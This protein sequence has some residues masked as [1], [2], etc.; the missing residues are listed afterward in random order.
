MEAC[1][2]AERAANT[3]ANTQKS[4]GLGL[5][6]LGKAMDL[7][8]KGLGLAAAG[9]Q[10]ANAAKQQGASSD[11]N[12]QMSGLGA[13]APTASSINGASASGPESASLGTGKDAPTSPN[14]GIGNSNGQGLVVAS[15]ATPGAGFTAGASGSM[16][17]GGFGSNG[18]GTNGAAVTA[19]ASSPAGGGGGGGGASDSSGS[20]RPRDGVAGG[21]GA[22]GGSPGT[23]YEM[24]AGGGGGKPMLGMKG[25]KAD[26]DEFTGAAADSALGDLG[27]RDL[28]STGDM[29]AVDVAAAESES[30]FERV[31]IKYSNLKVKGRF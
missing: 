5:G 28:A 3:L 8:T 2:N 1:I 27:H 21:E 4:D 29:Q 26:L 22:G 9:M 23:N 30:I 17:G 15:K 31:R 10:M 24:N 13:T 11:P 18:L 6:D 19:A 25:S 14:V 16:G 12:S 20:S 7:A